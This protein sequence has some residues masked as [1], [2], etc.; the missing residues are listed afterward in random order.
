[1]YPLRQ[2]TRAPDFPLHLHEWILPFQIATYSRGFYCDF[3]YRPSSPFPNEN[4]V[5]QLTEG[6]SDINYADKGQISHDLESSPLE[7]LL[8][9]KDPLTIMLVGQNGCSLEPPEQSIA[10]TIVES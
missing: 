6:A 2:L 8:Y 4:Q 3:V 9:A 7:N 1:M 5:N 10:W